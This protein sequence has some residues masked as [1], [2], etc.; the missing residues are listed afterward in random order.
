MLALAIKAEIMATMAIDGNFN[1]D[2][3]GAHIKVRSRID[4]V[5]FHVFPSKHKE[6]RR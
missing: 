1:G 3:L 5:N 6:M 2:Y 4:N